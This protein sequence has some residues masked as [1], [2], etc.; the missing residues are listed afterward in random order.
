MMLKVIYKFKN[1]NKSDKK[2]LD[3]LCIESNQEVDK[4]SKHW[5]LR[6][7]EKFIQAI[8]FVRI[9]NNLVVTIPNPLNLPLSTLKM[10]TKKLKMEKTIEKWLNEHGIKNYDKNYEVV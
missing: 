7:W 9:E 2:D 3:N 6:Q 10:M 4:L 5:S 8:I 1:L